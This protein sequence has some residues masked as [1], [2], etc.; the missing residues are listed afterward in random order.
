MITDVDEQIGRMLAALDAT[1]KA[2]NTIVLV[3]SDHGDMLGSHG[4]QYK[5]VPWEESILV[6]G[7]LRY[8]AK[9]KPGQKLDTLFAHVDIAPTFLGFCGIEVPSAMQGWDLSSR[10]RG[11]TAAE[12]DWALLQHFVVSSGGGK[13]LPWR[14]IRTKTHTYARHADAPW[15]L[16]DLK[17]DPY[18]MNNLAE[19]PASERLRAQ[20]DNSIALMMRS[21]EDSWDVN[22]NEDIEKTIQL[23]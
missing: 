2:E 23:R 4:R 6:P 3:T 20:L 13:S 19:D 9:V 16:Y 15:L 11:I 17:A 22:I 7:I 5:R 1:G 18:Q 21:N 12:P 14:G 8:P 10:L